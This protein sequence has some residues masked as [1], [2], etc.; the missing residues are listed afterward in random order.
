M[1]AGR[2]LVCVVDDEH[3]VRMGLQRLFQ[4][5]GYPVEIFSSAEAYLAHEPFETP[6][7]LVLD[8]R[9]PVLNGLALQE[10]LNARG[11]GEQIVFMSG[12][13]DVPTCA[14]AMKS[15]AVDFLIKPFTEEALFAA[16]DR[17][18][19][20]S[21]EASQQRNEYRHA[22]ERLTSLT[23]REFDVLRYVISGLLNKQIAAELGAT[24]KTI[25]VHRGRV[26]EKIGM[27]SVADLVRFAERARVEPAVIAS[28]E[29]R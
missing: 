20:R 25:K 9:M 11:Y 27:R 29:K 15:G 8:V 1:N 24:E 7:C 14:Q 18:L 10:T 3:S 5:A 22:R 26:M 12:H 2:Q 23:P 13:S 28:S 17:A 4:S 19:Q 6:Y 21:A 16:V